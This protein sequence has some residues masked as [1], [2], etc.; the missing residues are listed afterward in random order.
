MQT[1]WRGMDQARLDR[2]YD[3]RAT[4]PDFAVE[5]RRYAELSAQARVAL[6]MQPDL[7]FDAESGCALDW[8]VGAP[9]GPVL[10]WIHGGFWRALAKSDQ[11]LVA[12]GLVAAGAHV[13]VMDYSLAPAASLDTMV[14]QARLALAFV[15]AHAREHGAD[16]AR[17][18]AGGHSA[19]GQLVGMLL[20]PDWQQQYDLPADALRGGVVVSGLFDLEPVRLSYVNQW[21]QLGAEAAHR[22]S[23]LHHIPPQGPAPR[24]LATCGG[25]ETAE[26]RRQTEEYA[27][28]WRAAGHSAQIAPQPARHHFDI[29]VAL[30]DAADPLCREAAAFMETD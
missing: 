24:L 7:M 6:P 11:S 12:P 16:P 27:A 14:H 23:P 30:G 19:G 15:A 21:L 4:V 18:F 28:A 29:V 25:R 13:A 22:L 3:A 8:F 5:A 20:A 26:F 2:E 9:G 10:L 1:L 17:L